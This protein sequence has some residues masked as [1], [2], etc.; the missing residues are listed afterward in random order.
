MPTP[1]F[2]VDGGATWSSN[3]STSSGRTVLARIW[4]HNDTDATIPNTSIT[5]LLPSGTTL[6]PNSTQNS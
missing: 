1:L 6:T 2:S 5:T 3:V 4:S